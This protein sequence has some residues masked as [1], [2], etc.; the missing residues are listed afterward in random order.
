MLVKE[1]A[2]KHKVSCRTVVDWI[3]RGLLTVRRKGHGPTSPWLILEDKD[4]QEATQ[5]T[6]MV[7]D[8]T[9]LVQEFVEKQHQETQRIRAALDADA[10]RLAGIPE[11]IPEPHYEFDKDI[12]DVPPEDVEADRYH[13]W[14]QHK[15]WDEP[16]GQGR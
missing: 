9:A 14:L 8:T 5:V 1:Y 7:K 11:R 6:R 16:D 10:R 2:D 13:Q 3:R 12:Q 15:L 4:I